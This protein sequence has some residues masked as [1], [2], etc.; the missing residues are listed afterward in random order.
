MFRSYLDHLVVAAPTLEAGADYVRRALG[1][2]PDPGGAHARMGTHN[3]LLNLGGGSYLEVIAVDP[4]APTPDRPRW[5]QLDDPAVTRGPRL[6]TWVA[7]TDDIYAAVAASPVPLGRIESMTRGRLEW[8]ITVPEDGRLILDGIAPLLIQWP[9]GMHPTR[10]L[11]DR[12]CRLYSL[13]GCHARADT[14]AALLTAIGFENA[15]AFT[16][17]PGERP[18]LAA[19]VR[20][21]DGMRELRGDA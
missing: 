12:G 20:T 21:P 10:T 7:R 18:C 6:I 9:E 3:R 5:F 16:P 1:V 2:A 17:A 15:A 13:R 8:L 11:A 19:T 4:Q 14:I